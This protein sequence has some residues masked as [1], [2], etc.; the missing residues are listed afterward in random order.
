M[1]VCASGVNTILLF[2]IISRWVFELL[3][4]FL[5]D[6]AKEQLFFTLACDVSEMSKTPLPL[7]AFAL[8][9]HFH[10]SFP[11]FAMFL[12]RNRS[13]TQQSC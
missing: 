3:L 6:A 5:G 10:T 2:A 4:Q 9:A 12:S 13:N 7:I 11:F 8:L 1:C